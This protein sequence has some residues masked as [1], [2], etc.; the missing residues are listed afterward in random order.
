M[1]IAT[2][3]KVERLLKRMDALEME[4]SELRALLQ[5]YVDNQKLAST[6]PKDSNGRINRK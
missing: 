5:Q 4:F 1:S 2:E 3:Q 6:P